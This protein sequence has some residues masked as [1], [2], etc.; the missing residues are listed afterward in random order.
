MGYVYVE[1]LEQ[2]EEAGKPTVQLTGTDGNVFAL[3]GECKKAMLRYQ[4]EIDPKYNAKLM[5]QEM[6]DEINQG[7]YDNALMVMMGYCE[8]L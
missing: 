6:W 4:R 2:T 7:D 8:V 1:D 5:F 3:M